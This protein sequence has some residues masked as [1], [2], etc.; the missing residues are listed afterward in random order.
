MSAGPEWSDLIMRAR[1][2]RVRALELEAIAE[3]TRCPERESGG[4]RCT[5]D[6]TSEHQCRISQDDLPPG[7]F[8]VNETE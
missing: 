1:N 2:L 5:L 4:V 7:S 3:A 8:S 6:G